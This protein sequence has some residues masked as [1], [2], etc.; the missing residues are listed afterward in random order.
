MLAFSPAP[1]APVPAAASAGLPRNP[2]T[3]QMGVPAHVPL[4]GGVATNPF[5]MMQVGQ[6]EFPGMVLGEQ[7]Q[8]LGSTHGF[9]A[10]AGPGAQGTF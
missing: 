4:S 1:F 2:F 7:Q 5:S 10:W 8:P 9:S 3:P 6:G